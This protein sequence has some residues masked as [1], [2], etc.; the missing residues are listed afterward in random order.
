MILM[1]RKQ[2]IT[3]MKM[4]PRKQI[5]GITNITPRKQ[6]RRIV[7][8][9]EQRRK[10]GV[11]CWRSFQIRK[12]SLWCWFWRWLCWRWGTEWGRTLILA[13]D[14]CSADCDRHLYGS[15]KQI[16]K[17]TPSDNCDEVRPEFSALHIASAL[18]FG[19]QNPR[20]EHFFLLRFLTA[21]A[22]FWE[23]AC[24]L[25]DW[26]TMLVFRVWVFVC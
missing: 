22:W 6:I 5:R 26:P 8:A 9:L 24:Y 13:G 20:G 4:P 12:S 17:A 11:S 23:G 3:T 21:A 2:M 14:H 7:P 1:T 25:K 18:G 19:V 16:C 10:S 15:P